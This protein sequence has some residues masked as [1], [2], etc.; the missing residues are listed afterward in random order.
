MLSKTRRRVVIGG[1]TALLLLTMPPMC[2]KV[3]AFEKAEYFYLNQERFNRT[4]RM[5]I[6]NAP[7]GKQLHDGAKDIVIGHLRNGTKVLLF[8][9]E[10]GNVHDDGGYLFASRD[11]VLPETPGPHT[12]DDMSRLDLNND[13]Q[14]QLEGSLY[15]AE[16]L[17]PG[18]YV[19]Y[20]DL[21]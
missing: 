14:D 7:N 19:V 12:D 6:S 18:W 1:V 3:E 4:A 21:Y 2:V 16:R 17:N 15:V 10:D 11:I 13:I 8:P 5:M 20:T 9:F